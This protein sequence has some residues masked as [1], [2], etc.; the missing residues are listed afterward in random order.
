MDST[1]Q[2]A[3]NATKKRRLPRKRTR[4]LT[5]MPTAQSNP[6]NKIRR[7]RSAPPI[8][9][10][11]RVPRRLWDLPDELR[12]HICKY[13][14]LSDLQR[15]SVTCR[16]QQTFIQDSAKEI[17]RVIVNAS[18]QRLRSE[19][20]HIYHV[21]T[22]Q[23]DYLGFMRRFFMQRGFPPSRARWNSVVD[24]LVSVWMLR[25][26]SWIATINK[27]ILNN[28]VFEKCI[29]MEIGLRGITL[30][31]MALHEHFHIHGRGF[32]PSYLSRVAHEW[33]G[34]MFCA[35]LSEYGFTD[36]I[37]ANWYITLA[38]NL[39]S[40]FST[41][42]DLQRSSVW[43][44]KLLAPLHDIYPVPTSRHPI[45]PSAPNECFALCTN[46]RLRQI[47]GGCNAI[48]G[49]KRFLS[50]GFSRRHWF[51]ICARSDSVYAMVREVVEGRRA[52]LSALQRCVVLE[53][54]YI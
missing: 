43:R 35:V 3:G 52:Q 38:V 7:R 15:L 25:D 14:S 45:D 5:G 21:D 9:L 42:T 20:N 53:D 51:A 39:P 12:V 50:K 8:L 23:C 41:Q 18:Q 13:V 33:A 11:P 49:A 32:S 6:S 44:R 46:A 2:P 24:T 1:D 10:P 28:E 26:P 40:Y 29:E 30:A 27:S 17:T 31:L 36:T 16:E 37:L 47:L 19:L 4:S 22:S 54:I 34:V 48:E